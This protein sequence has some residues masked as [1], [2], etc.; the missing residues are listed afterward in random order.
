MHTARK[1]GFRITLVYLALGDPELHIE[2][3]S[4]RVEQGGHNVPDVDI[5]RRYH[6]S[7]AHAPEAIRLADETLVLD[8]AGLR[9]TRV[10]EIRDGRISW[11][12]SS[13]PAWVRDLLVRIG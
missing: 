2:R 1:A 10:M 13:L 8:N 11:Q 12:S 6:R 5:R 3:V 7:L 4:Q 9:P